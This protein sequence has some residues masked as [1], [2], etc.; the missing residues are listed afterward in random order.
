MPRQHRQDQEDQ[1]QALHLAVR[2]EEGTLGS[3]STGEAV[4]HRDRRRDQGAEDVPTDSHPQGCRPWPDGKN[5]ENGHRSESRNGPLRSRDRGTGRPLGERGELGHHRVPIHVDV[6]AVRGAGQRGRVNL[7]RSLPRRTRFDRINSLRAIHAD[8]SR[9]RNGGG[10]RRQGR[11]TR[12]RRR[13][14]LH[15]VRADPL[16]SH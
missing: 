5:G 1:D 7:R 2:D 12:K 10:I 3:R 16:Q 8:R 13:P 6:S 14:H 11:S 9:Q 15:P 4:D